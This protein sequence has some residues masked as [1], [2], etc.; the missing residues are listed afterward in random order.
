MINAFLFCM[1]VQS[2][3]KR[4]GYVEPFEIVPQPV[5]VSRILIENP[6]FGGF[7]PSNIDWYDEV[8]TA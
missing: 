8:M 3:A 2:S 6:C 7:S 1:A 4:F 5:P